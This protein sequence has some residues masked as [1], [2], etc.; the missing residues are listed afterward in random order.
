MMA[1][2][3]PGIPPPV[4]AKEPTLLQS[5]WIDDRRR[6]TIADTDHYRRQR[7]GQVARQAILL[8]AS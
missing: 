1:L 4:A 6:R 8:M 5:P 7:L 3:S 2:L